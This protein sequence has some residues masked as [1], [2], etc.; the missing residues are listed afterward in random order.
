M[1]GSGK[2]EVGRILKIFSIVKVIFGHEV[3]TLIFR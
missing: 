2:A 3:N 1:I